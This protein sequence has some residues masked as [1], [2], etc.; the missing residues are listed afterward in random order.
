MRGEVVDDGES[1]GTGGASWGGSNRRRRL[2]RLHGSG[3]EIRWLRRL[4]EKGRWSRR[5]REERGRC[6][7][8]E[9]SEGSC[10]F[11]AA[12]RGRGAAAKST[13]T[14]WLQRRREVGEGVAWCC[15]SRRSSW[16]QRRGWAVPN[17][18]G[19]KQSAA[20]PWRKGLSPPAT[21]GAGRGNGGVCEVPSAVVILKAREGVQGRSA[22]SRRRVPVA[23][24]V[25]PASTW[26]CRP[27]RDWASWAWHGLGL[28]V[29]LST[30]GV[31]QV[32]Q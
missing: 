11:I 27:W 5:V 23:R 7:C 30:K 20:R 19:S 24:S 1:P 31:Y 15:V 26:P 6:W 8:G 25:V 22:S 10:P 2:R 16:R 28:V 12:E 3:D 32:V 14:A 29:L 4:I 9:L 21:A 18:V 17:L 13:S